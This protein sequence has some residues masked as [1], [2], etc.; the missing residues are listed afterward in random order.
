MG[1]LKEYYLNNLTEEEINEMAE[2]QYF[3]QELVYELKEIS[4]SQSEE[5]MDTHQTYL[6]DS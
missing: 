4:T 6:Y 1:I 3:R 5:D 2:E